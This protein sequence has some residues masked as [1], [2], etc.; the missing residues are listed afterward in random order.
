MNKH[1]L[2]ILLDENRAGRPTVCNA[3]KILYPPRPSGYGGS[4]LSSFRYPAYIHSG[5]RENHD[6]RDVCDVLRLAV[7]LKLMR[8][9]GAYVAR[10][11]KRP[12]RRKRLRDS[13]LVGL[14]D[15]VISRFDLH[16]S[17]KLLIF[18]RSKDG[19]LTCVYESK[20]TSGESCH[21]RANEFSDIAKRYCGSDFLL[22]HSHPHGDVAPSGTDIHFHNVIKRLLAF[23]GSRLFEHIIV[24]VKNGVTVYR[25]IERPAGYYD[26]HPLSEIVK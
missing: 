5:S 13:N 17:E 16:S 4:F 7:F 12:A 3:C 24:S 19:Y 6:N 2:A 15:H 20:S 11:N 21:I 25:C 9:S 8:M 18:T 10:S 1:K 23:T 14:L 26:T 22:I